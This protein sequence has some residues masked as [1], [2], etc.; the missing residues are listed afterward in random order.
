MSIRVV[1][2]RAAAYE[3]G[4]DS[5]ALQVQRYRCMTPA[6]RWRQACELR[7][8]A[9]A[10]K[11]AWLRQQHPEWSQTELDRHVREIF[12]YATT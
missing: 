2:E 5:R 1:T 8:M 10:L 3:R 9:V 6:E 7:D 4:V 11:S 12:L